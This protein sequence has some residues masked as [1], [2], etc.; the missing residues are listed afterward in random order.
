MAL[1]DQ[2]NA[3]DAFTGHWALNARCEVSHLLRAILAGQSTVVC[4]T[5]AHSPMGVTSSG[6]GSV[7]GRWGKTVAYSN[8]VY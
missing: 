8:K 2:G 5:P 3:V 7:G 6:E 1:V 4:L